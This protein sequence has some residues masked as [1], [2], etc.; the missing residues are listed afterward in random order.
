MS[1]LGKTIRTVLISLMLGFLIVSFAITGVGANIFV[2]SSKVIATV[3]DTEIETANLVR[4]VQNEAQRYQTQFGLQ[5]SAPEI[6]ETFQL[7]NQILQRN[8]AISAFTESASRMKLRGTDKQVA[9]T[10]KDQEIFQILN[11]RF[12]RNV[13]LQI[14][15]R[16]GLT[17]ADFEKSTKQ[18]LARTQLIEALQAN[19][20]MPKLLA[21]NLYSYRN[22]MR[23]AQIYALP[24]SIITTTPEPKE[25]DLQAYYDANKAN[26]MEP[27]NRTFSY[28]LLTPESFEPQVEVDE[29]KLL[30]TYEY[31]KSEY[32]T[33]SS[34]A[35]LQVSLETRALADTLIERVK[36][37]EDFSKVAA[38]LSEFTEEE[39]D[40]GT[41][42]AAD[43]EAD[44][45]K[46]VSDAVFALNKGDVS[47]VFEDFAGFSVFKV[48]GINSGTEK[49]FE[50]VK[51][52]LTADY[53]KQGA[54]DL[55]YDY[56]DAVSEAMAEYDTLVDVA[57][58]LNRDL[59]TMSNVRANGQFVD[60]NIT[61]DGDIEKIILAEAF[62]SDIEG[63]LEIKNVNRDAD[64][65]SAY[66]MQVSQINEAKQKEFEEVKDD[67]LRAWQA[68]ENRIALGLVAEKALSRIRAGESIDQVM[69]DLGGTSYN[70]NNVRRDS[71]QTSNIAANLRNLIFTTN[72]GESDMTSAA[73]GDGYLIAKVMTS[74]PAD[75]AN[76]SAQVDVIM[77]QLTS[78]FG[79]EI[80]S[81]YQAHLLNTYDIWVNEP[82]L[83]Q[84]FNQQNQSALQ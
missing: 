84:V 51:D 59:A 66:L 49:T 67:V 22:E 9:D 60:S 53:I 63:F 39:I 77:T 62:K 48:T 11:G 45:E 15:D 54:I 47:D 61:V 83:Y 23:N 29:A 24:Q 79:N 46:A 43:L 19:T 68:S 4:E 52:E 6:I 42:T 70:V 3:G 14:L 37:G 40:L 28:M 33:P 41:M 38:E 20:P 78:Q 32:V 81:Q 31:R 74:I 25:G 10:L 36:A 13:M 35:L 27:E 2:S 75:V 73:D 44:Y 58:Y 56:L 12:D 55:L 65:I 50:D 17:Y 72:I 16:A 1:N 26:Y 80:L 57:K 82:L 64:D 34:R 18:D 21:E 76:N 71:T 69:A 5:M 7:Q 8:V 30:E